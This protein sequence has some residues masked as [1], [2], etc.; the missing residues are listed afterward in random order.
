MLTR[1]ARVLLVITV[2]MASGC[3]N[4]RALFDGM[5]PASA[6][7]VHYV[8]ESRLNIGV[9]FR[10]VSSPN[11]YQY[12]DAV[13]QKLHSA[14]YTLC[15]KSAITKWVPRPFDPREAAAP[16]FW[17]NE[18]YASKGYGSFFL[19]RVDS[20]PAVNG[21]TWNQ[22]FVLSEQIIHD[23]KQNMANIREFCD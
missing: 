21:L 17:I 1:V 23:G 14:G 16:A 7:S 6:T 15:N 10:L 13:R 19:V 5:V 20:I 2:L 22:K 4:R 8:D 11:S 12:V 9:K 3:T 18:L